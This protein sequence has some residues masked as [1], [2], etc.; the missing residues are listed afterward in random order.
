MQDYR[1]KNKSRI[2]AHRHQWRS[3]NKDKMRRISSKARL[4]KVYGITP[5]EYDAMLLKQ[6]G[7]CA[8]CK[9]PASKY[10]RKLHVDHNHTTG[11]NRGLLCVRCNSG[12][13]HFK[14]NPTLL[15]AAK[16]YL[17]QYNNALK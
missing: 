13:G 14:E 6:N 2:A 10:K 4:K 11:E 8:I 15:D 7:C 3:D 1:K 12:I 5:D 16:D 17:L 9:T